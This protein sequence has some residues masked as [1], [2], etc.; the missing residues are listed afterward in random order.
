MTIRSLDHVNIRTPQVEA[1]AVFFRDALG[2]TVTPPPGL[3]PGVRAAWVLD[4]A[5]KPV[6][7]IGDADG[8]YPTD[9]HVP[10]VPARG[11]GSV[12]HIAFNC[13]D[14]HGIR[15]RLTRYGI[16]ASEN[17]MAQIGLRQVFVHDPNGIFVELNF[18]TEKARGGEGPGQ[19]GLD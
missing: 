13:D 10:F 9:G 8:V 14:Y 3:Q 7:H 17:Y 4:D 11:G 2:M 19:E 5:G 6:V 1:T 15:Q 12:H 18:W 16:E